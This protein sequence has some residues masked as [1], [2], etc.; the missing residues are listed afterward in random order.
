[1]NV[2]KVPNESAGNR[3]KFFGGQ[4]KTGT[5]WGNCTVNSRS[6]DFW[7]HKISKTSE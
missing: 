2:D 5:P 6:E 1:M 3:F 4:T 7:T